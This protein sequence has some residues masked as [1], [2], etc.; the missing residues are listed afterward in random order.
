MMAVESSTYWDG[1]APSSAV[2]GPFLSK[3][4]SKVLGPLSLVMLVV[5]ASAVHESNIFN[6][7]TLET[8]DPKYFLL[9]FLCPISWGTHVAA[10][11]QKQNGN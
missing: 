10:W 6:T 8:I 3:M 5:G 2:L 4:P 7:V 9:S 1:K 11:I